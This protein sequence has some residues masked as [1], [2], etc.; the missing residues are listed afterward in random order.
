[1]SVTAVDELNYAV[2]QIQQKLNTQNETLLPEPLDGWTAGEVENTSAAMAI[3]GTDTFA[4]YADITNGR[5]L[6]R[7]LPAGTYDLLLQ[8][9]A[10][11]GY[12]DT[13]LAGVG[14][15]LGQATDVGTISLPQ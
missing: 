1:M 7:G 6:I 5:F 13:T 10:A 8:P 12:Q 9:A 14:V 2:A 3:M 15:S 11:S 4:S